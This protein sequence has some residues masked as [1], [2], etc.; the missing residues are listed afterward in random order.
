MK[1]RTIRFMSSQG[2][3]YS[4]PFI[5][6]KEELSGAGPDVSCDKTWSQITSV[7]SRVKTLEEFKRGVIWAQQQYH[8]PNPRPATQT[9]ETRPDE[10]LTIYEDLATTGVEEEAVCTSCKLETPIEF[11]P[12]GT[13]EGLEVPCL[14][15]GGKLVPVNEDLPDPAFWRMLLQLCRVKPG[16]YTIAKNTELKDKVADAHKGEEI[17]RIDKLVKVT[18]HDG[19]FQ[20]VFK[21]KTCAI[22]PLSSFRGNPNFKEED[23]YLPEQKAKH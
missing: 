13:F 19:Y 17:S 6:D 3:F 4:P 5:G 11:K 20:V 22:V 1:T 23:I 14:A 7:M 9:M 8:M 16:V 10:I 18:K 12:D 21:D 15:C 2:W